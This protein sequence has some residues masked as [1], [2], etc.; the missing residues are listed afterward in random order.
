MID[1]FQGDV[2]I[3]MEPDGADMQFIGG[4]PTMEAGLE[5]LALISLFTLPGF[6]GNTLIDDVNQHITSEFEV[7][8]KGP[9]NLK[10]L[11]S[12]RQNAEK[13]LNDEALG[14]K[15]ITVTNP[16][17]IRLDLFALLYPPGRD[18]MEL[19]VSKFYQNWQ[20]QALKENDNGN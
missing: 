11:E 6:W 16:K 9:I 18:V 2:K 8:A 15:E 13:S 17:N 1:R 4:Q 10:K 20:N 5:N 14:E 12:I 7:N 19:K 3:Y